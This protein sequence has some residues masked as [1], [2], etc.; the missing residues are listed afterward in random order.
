L[1]VVSAYCPNCGRRVYVGEQD[2]RVCPVCNG[3]LDI[4]ELETPRAERI[5]EN[6]AMF[7]EVNVRIDRA[8]RNDQDSEKRIEE[9]VCECS[10]L[11]CTQRIAIRVGEY[12]KIRSHPNRYAIAHEHD[13]PDVEVVVDRLPRYWV[14]EKTGRAAESAEE[15][16]EARDVS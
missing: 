2:E 10:S 13:V 5:G 9:F 4:T 6:E 1:P 15:S 8:R 12:E 7:R 14:V 11:D 16:K 3:P